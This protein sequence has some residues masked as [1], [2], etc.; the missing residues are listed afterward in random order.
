MKNILVPTDFSPAATNAAKYALNIAKSV[1]ANIK[2]CNAVT[3]PAESIYA[4]QVAWPMDD[5]ATLK[6]GAEAEL[7]YQA[8]VLES[9]IGDGF[10]PHISHSTGMG[11]VTD[12]VRNTVSDD[13]ISMVVMGMSGANLFSKFLLGSNSR[14]LINKADFPL[15]LIPKQYVYKPIN[16]IAFATDLSDSDIDALHTVANFARYFNAQILVSHVMEVA[17]QHQRKVEEFL[18]DVTCRINYPNIYYRSL[19]NDGVNA[20]LNWLTENGKIDMLVMIHH[21][22]SIFDSS[23]TQ[24]LAIKSSVPLLVLPDGFNKVLI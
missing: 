18:S 20:G 19:E 24:R 9:S 8:D 7:I 4:A 23:H 11:N 13:K 16:K 17:N 21:A 14:D 6:D 15:L 1:N 10:R 12:Y 3:V 2:L 22:H 5:L